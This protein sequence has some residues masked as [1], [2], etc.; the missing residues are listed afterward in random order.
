M[1]P[2][3]PAMPLRAANHGAE[4]NPIRHAF[5]CSFDASLSAKC[6]VRE[7]SASAGRGVPGHRADAAVRPRR[8]RNAKTSDKRVVPHEYS[9]RRAEAKKA[10]RRRRHNKAIRDHARR[11]D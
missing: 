6:R 10:L 5:F 4:T 1:L 3:A 9:E 7:A 8:C 11:D 2:D